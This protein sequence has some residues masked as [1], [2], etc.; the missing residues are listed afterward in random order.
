M[1]V[2]INCLMNIFVRF[3]YRKNTANVAM[4]Y[5]WTEKRDGIDGMDMTKN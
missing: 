2:I 4:T 1:K 3:L 5:L